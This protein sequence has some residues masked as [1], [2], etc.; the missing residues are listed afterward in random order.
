MNRT[1]LHKLVDALPEKEIHTAA[2]FLSFV[3]H[4]AQELSRD[5]FFDAAPYDEDEYTEEELTVI[6][7]RIK[8]AQGG[9]TIP[10]AQVKT[11]HGLT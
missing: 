1:D 10:F 6:D 2:A 7:E 4:R 11:E 9:Q 8:E 5:G 3:T